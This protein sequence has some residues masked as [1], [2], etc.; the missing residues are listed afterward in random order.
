MWKHRLR[1]FLLA[2]LAIFSGPCGNPD[3]VA[4]QSCEK[5][6]GIYQNGFCGLP[7]MPEE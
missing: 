1:W 4:Q 6:G 2:S 5:Q 7:L 3:Q